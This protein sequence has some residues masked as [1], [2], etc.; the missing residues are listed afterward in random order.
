MLISVLRKRPIWLNFEVHSVNARIGFFLLQYSLKNIQPERYKIVHDQLD[1]NKKKLQQK[2]VPSLGTP[3]IGRD[4]N[5]DMNRLHK[6]LSPL[7]S[8]NDQN[9]DAKQKDKHA[10]GSRGNK[11]V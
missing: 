11:R 3:C 5:V 8:L 4:H 9:L 7:V 6:K 1:R 10:I 2:V